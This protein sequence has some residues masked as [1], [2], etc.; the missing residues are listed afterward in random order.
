MLRFIVEDNGMGIPKNEIDRIF[1]YGYRATNVR[2][3]PTMGGGFGLTKA[4]Y[5]TVQLNG[6]LWIES[7]EDAGT[8]ITIEIPVPEKYV[9]TRVNKSNISVEP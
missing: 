9:A 6:D 2:H 8:K 5:I 7:E 1:D 4:L 3:L